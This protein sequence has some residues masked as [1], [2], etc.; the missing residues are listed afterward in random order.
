M[1]PSGGTNPG[2]LIRPYA[3]TGGRTEASRSDLA[4]EDLVTTQ[5]AARSPSTT[6]V[7]DEHRSIMSL[8][9]GVTISLA[10]VSA[11]LHFPLGVTRILVGDLVDQGLLRIHRAEAGLGADGRPDEYLLKRV[12][13]RLYSL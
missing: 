1:P 10:E 9:A 7:A 11:R 13:G 5:A 2:P 12:L 3:I 8:C 4:I 6:G